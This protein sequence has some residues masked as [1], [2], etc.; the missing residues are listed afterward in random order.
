[1]CICSMNRLTSIRWLQEMTE[2]HR[3]I[4]YLGHRQPGEDLVLHPSFESATV[5]FYT[6][7]IA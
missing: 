6:Q 3:A 4:R 2:Q 1:M 5:G 7:N